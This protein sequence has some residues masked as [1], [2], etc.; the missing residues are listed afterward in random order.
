[1]S[2]QDVK[3]I[4]TPITSTTSTSSS[5]ATP[6][7]RYCHPDFAR[8]KILF[9]VTSPNTEELRAFLRHIHAPYTFTNPD[10]NTVIV[11]IQADGS[12]QFICDV[13]D[14]QP[15]PRASTPNNNLVDFDNLSLSSSLTSLSDSNAPPAKP[16]Y[17][18]TPILPLSICRFDPT[19]RCTCGLC[20]F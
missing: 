1:M 20:S 8:T 12:N 18:D 17:F 13:V 14:P 2:L 4:I 6:V 11:Q 7:S 3:P 15:T 9:S 16:S 5:A 19:L 10:S